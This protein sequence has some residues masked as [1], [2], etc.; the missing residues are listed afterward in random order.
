MNIDEPMDLNKTEEA[1]SDQPT[2]EGSDCYV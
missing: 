1:N 2:A